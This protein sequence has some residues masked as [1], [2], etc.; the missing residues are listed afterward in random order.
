MKRMKAFVVLTCLFL[1][2]EHALLRADVVECLNGDRYNGKLLS[3]DEKSV[4]LE[5]EVTGVMTLPRAK[6]SS[7]HFGAVERRTETLT[8]V[9]SAA[10]IIRK[11]DPDAKPNSTTKD[12]TKAELDPKAVEQVQNEFLAGASPEAQAMFKNMVQGLMS[13][14]LNMQDLRGQAKSALDQ[15]KDLEKDLDEDETSALLGSY[16]GILQNFLKETA[17]AIPEPAKPKEN[18]PKKED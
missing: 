14:S 2:S 17:K 4:K 10:D 12:P 18:A 6:V 16:V 11:L 5:S 1:G 9:P 8:K 13:G 15:L 3:V 7:I